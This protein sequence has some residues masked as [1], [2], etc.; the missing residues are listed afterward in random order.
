VIAEM[1][2]TLAD[3]AEAWQRERGEQV[4]ERDSA[5]WDAMYQDWVDYAFA[6]I[7]VSL[8]NLP[9]RGSK[10]VV[11]R[12]NQLSPDLYLNA[13]G[14]WG[15]YGKAKRFRSQDRAEQFARRHGVNVFGLF[16]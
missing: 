11:I 16:E 1:E 14:R 2:M 4:P 15:A 5:A 3:H 7:P 12:K 6:D 10:T 8:D 13:A 9:A